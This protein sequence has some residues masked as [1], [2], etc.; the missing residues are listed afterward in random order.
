MPAVDVLKLRGLREASLTLVAVFG[1]AQ[2]RLPASAAP[3]AMT[4]KEIEAY[5]RALDRERFWA[6]LERSPKRDHLLRFWASVAIQDHVL[7]CI[8]RAKPTRYQLTAFG[9]RCAG[10]APLPAGA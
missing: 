10:L 2:E 4:Y 5:V 3:V 7:E 1:S 6:A 8:D 9:R